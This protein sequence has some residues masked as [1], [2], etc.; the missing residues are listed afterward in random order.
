MT[1]DVDAMYHPKIIGRRGA[2]IT[3]IRQNNE[4]NIQFAA[5]GETDSPNAIIITGYEQ[6]CES[7]R[8]EILK[9]VRDLVSNTSPVPLHS[10]LEQ[11]EFYV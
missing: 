9:I 4:V 8:D 1:V 7:A 5:K 6:N 10:L 2:V 3:K 11:L